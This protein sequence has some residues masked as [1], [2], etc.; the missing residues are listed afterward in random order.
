MNK[1]IVQ[2]RM[3]LRTSTQLKN[4][5]TD[6]TYLIPQPKEDKNMNEVITKS[7]TSKDP[8]FG[9]NFSYF[10][11][12]DM[13]WKL[14]EFDDQYINILN[15]E[16]S[17]LNKEDKLCELQ[18]DYHRKKF[19][20]KKKAKKAGEEFKEKESD[21]IQSMR[22]GLNY[23]ERTSQTFNAEILT[24]D[25]ETPKL[26][27]NDHRGISHKWDLF[28]RYLVKYV[29]I[30]EEKKLENAKKFGILKKERAKKVEKQVESLAK[31]SLIKTLKL[32]E[33]QI[34]QILNEYNYKFYREWNRQDESPDSKQVIMLLAFPDDRSYRN[35]SV[36]AICWNPK[37]EDL[38]AIG[39]GSYA[40]PKKKDDKEKSEDNQERSDDILETGFIF[41]YSV[42]NNHHPEIKYTTESG[43]LSLDFHPTQFSLLVAG[44]YD[45]TV[46]VYDIKQKVKTP[47]L[48]CD[49]RYQ[50]HMDPV[51]Q[52]KWYT[53]T[54]SNEYVFY[55]ISSDGKVIK[56]SFFKNKTKLESEEII[57]LKYSDS[58]Q[59]IAEKIQ[60]NREIGMME[61]DTKEKAEEAFIFGNSGGMCFD[62]NK[63]KGYEHLFVLGTEEGHIHLCSVKH[64]GHYIQSYE[65]HTMGVYTVTWNPF[66]DKI[67]ASCSADW[68]IKIWHY[69]I[70]SPLII[71]DM[72]NA[73]G[74]LAWSPWCSTIFAAVTVMGDMKFFDLNRNRKGAI[75]DKKCHEIPINHISFN[76][77]EY[78]FLTGN[79]KG[80]VRLWRMAETLYQTPDKKEEEEK[81]KAKI[82][83]TNQKSTLPDLLVVPN[84]LKQATTK[85]KKMPQ[86][87]K[88][89]KMESVSS[90]AFIKHEKTRIN[91]FLNLL[92]VDTEL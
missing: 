5:D 54:E 59:E 74:D 85:Q 2:R 63:H 55:S 60:A 8:Q 35:R 22:N 9:R 86:I 26:L 76:R 71:F 21:S 66:H 83:A 31:P 75:H 42:K 81:E 47:I 37:F 1:P 65:G 30:E 45:G 52:V 10:S 80:K 88:D 39:C 92:G 79:D 32:V 6:T 11:Y 70:F 90:E 58:A 36:T 25:V 20:T 67:F 53:M 49:I 77:F 48:T 16:S 46:S 29:K 82:Q 61:S 56:W 24:K 14:E 69:K 15:L 84:N 13:Q 27:R 23:A 28:D 3:S 87:K 17:I 4:L 34:L 72:Q 7:L 38:F 89:N 50:K 91:E 73:V 41:V 12:V 43:V 18:N 33:K 68:T 40:F 62:F 78:V 57:T 44:M 19:Q 64:R 51:W